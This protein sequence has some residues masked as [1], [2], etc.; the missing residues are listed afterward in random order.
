MS[1]IDEWTDGFTVSSCPPAAEHSEAYCNCGEL[2]AKCRNCR[3]NKALVKRA[4]TAVT[5]VAHTFAQQFVVLSSYQLLQ[6]AVV[7]FSFWRV[8]THL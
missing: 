2:F 7:M 5:K 8:K 4:L 6:K 1:K 3:S